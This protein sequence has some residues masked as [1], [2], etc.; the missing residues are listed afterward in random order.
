MADFISTIVVIT[1]MIM[2]AMSVAALF[3]VFG[4]GVRQTDELMRAGVSFRAL[5]FG[6][7]KKQGNG[8]LVT[9]REGM[10]ASVDEE[11]KVTVRET[12]TIARDTL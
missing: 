1:I 10:R 5:L 7:V 9:V 12:R 6:S 11:G 4:S 2:L 3:H 8:S